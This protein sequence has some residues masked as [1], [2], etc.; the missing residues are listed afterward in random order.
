MQIWGEKDVNTLKQWAESWANRPEME[1][2]PYDVPVYSTGVMR[3]CE[4]CG[5]VFKENTGS[6]GDRCLECGGYGQQ[7]PIE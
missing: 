7:I 2:N 4:S 1:D 5:S 3:Q 6:S